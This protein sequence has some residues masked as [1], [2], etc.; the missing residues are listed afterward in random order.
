MSITRARVLS[1]GLAS[2]CLAFIPT[3]VQ[4]HSSVSANST[5]TAQRTG[6]NPQ[7]KR[8]ANSTFYIARPDL[9]R[10]ASPMCGGYFVRQVNSGLTRCANGRPM[11]EC[12]VASIDWNELAETEANDPL[13]DSTANSSNFTLSNMVVDIAKLNGA[14]LRGRIVPKG[15]RNGSYGVLK[16]RELWSPADDDKPYGDFYRVRDLGIRCIAAPCLTH[17]EAKL[18]TASVRNIAGVNLN[19]AGAGQAALTQAQTAITSSTGIIVA[20]GHSTVTGPAGQ[21]LTLKASQFYLR[22]GFVPHDSAELKPCM[23]TGCSGQICSD[24]EVIT[25]CEYRTEYECYKKATCERQ[26]SG[27]CG[28]TKTKELTDC[29]ARVR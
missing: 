17:Q 2:I 8:S 20:G 21:A 7:P 5:V 11:S 4:L 10:C 12:Y 24:H 23:K 18:N 16:V 13:S 26:A 29:L 19:E 15:N 27:E 6:R 25:T 3:A 14:L 9:R 28:F 22:Q 1:L